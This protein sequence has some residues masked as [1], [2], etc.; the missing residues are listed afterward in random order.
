[1]KNK[2]LALFPLAMLLVSL[3]PFH[4]SAQDDWY[5][6]YEDEYPQSSAGDRSVPPGFDAYYEEI[7]AHAVQQVEEFSM[8]MGMA[9]YVNEQVPI[10]QQGLLGDGL[11]FHHDQLTYF[12]NEWFD[13]FLIAGEMAQA[14]DQ[15]IILLEQFYAAGDDAATH[16][17]IV[18]RILPQIE[19]LQDANIYLENCFEE[20]VFWGLENY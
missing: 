3:V 7:R 16:M 1:M 19:A 6:E 10:A 12:A 4:A 8:H 15:D 13:T 18:L 11:F 14:L 9:A 20:M 2:I 5:D 17:L